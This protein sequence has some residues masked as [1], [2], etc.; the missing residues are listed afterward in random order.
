MKVISGKYKGRE[1]LVPKSGVKPTSEK[2]K[3][4]VINI[5]SPYLKGAKFLDIFAGTGAVGIEA[6]SNGASFC[7]FVE[8]NHKNYI[9]LKKNLENIIED[10][11]SYITIKHNAS[12]LTEFF[13]NRNIQPF[14]IIFADPFYDDL[15]WIFDDIILLTE[16]FLTKGG[17]FLLEHNCREKFDFH[18]LFIETRNYGDTSLTIFQ[19]R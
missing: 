14:E 17:L 9:L 8:N 12:R 11:N 6:L 13:K 7:C 18:P 10:K 1:I 19:K 16:D 3:Q 5:L 15:S 2:V 4:A